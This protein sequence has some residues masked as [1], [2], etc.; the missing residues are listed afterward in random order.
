MTRA[1]AL[2]RELYAVQQRLREAFPKRRFPLD[3]KLVGD[4]GEVIAAERYG[5]EL[6]GDVSKKGHDATRVDTNGLVLRV[7][8]KATQADTPGADIAFS[9]TV[10]DDPPDEFIVLVIR[11]DGSA[12]E[13]YNGPASP[14]L[15]ELK[16][17]AAP[18]GKQ[19]K[20]SLVAIRRI[21]ATVAGEGVRDGK[22]M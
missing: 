12:E 8:V 21:A 4:L 11:H 9:S 15:D 19:K 17:K 5:L 13:A 2:I 18:E 6:L 20:L 1:A 3:G 7:E 14:I 22:G 16:R 10:L